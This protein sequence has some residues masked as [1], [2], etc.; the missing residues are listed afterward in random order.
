MVVTHTNAGLQIIERQRMY[1][2]YG[3][4]LLCFAVFALLFVRGATGW[5]P[6]AA[7]LAVLFLAG[8][9]MLIRTA[10]TITALIKPD[11][12]VIIEYVRLYG[13]KRWV[14]NLTRADFTQVDYIR[15]FDTPKK[16][17][18]F[19]G[20]NQ[21][22]ES[23]ICLVTIWGA[24]ISVGTRYI[25][26]WSFRGLVPHVTAARPID[27]EAAQIAA[28]IGVPLH[29]IDAMTGAQALINFYNP[30]DS[31]RAIFGRP[32]QEQLDHEREGS[33]DPKAG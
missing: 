23:E 24:Q 29:T 11:G 13:G 31:M 8:G 17:V 14:R 10:E 25:A 1:A 5:Q 3:W 16:G 6:G 12:T 30:H 26:D 15:A 18:P 22:S 2:G 33:R 32:S 7:A 4:L 21:R 9:I 27:G 20:E 19:A 28:A